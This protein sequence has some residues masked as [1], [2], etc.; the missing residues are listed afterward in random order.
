[1]QSLA[2]LR[3]SYDQDAAG[4]VFE[5][6]YHLAFHMLS[7]WRKYGRPIPTAPECPRLYRGQRVDAWGVGA[8][9]YRGL[10]DRPDRDDELRKRAIRASEVGHAIAARLGLPFAE[11]MA[12]TQHYSADDVLGVPTWL[13]DFNRDPWVAL[14]FASDGGKTGEVGIVWDIT[15]K[16]YANHAAGED[17]PIGPLQLVVPRGVL[18]IDN[19]AGVFIVAGLPQIFDQYVASGWHTRFQQHTGLRFED[20]VLGVREEVIYPQTDPLLKELPEV[21]QSVLDCRC[22]RGDTPCDAPPAVF[23]DP[24]DAETYERLLNCWLNQF[25]AGQTDRHKP[26]RL[27]AALSNLARFHEGGRC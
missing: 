27:L 25:L 18:R 10:P 14:F 2:D 4:F 16:E 26:S 21:L 3:S 17:N 1:L 9:I 23:T 19:Q 15:P 6:V 11:A 8:K 20:P 7:S 24:L 5:D 13:V 12:V 22:G